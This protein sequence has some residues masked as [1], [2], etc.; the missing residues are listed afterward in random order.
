MVPGH[1]RCSNT[2]SGRLQLQPHEQGTLAT[3]TGPHRA[4]TSALG[5]GAGEGRGDWNGPVQDLLKQSSVFLALLLICLSNQVPGPSGPS[6]DRAWIADP[7]ASADEV[8]PFC[9]DCGFC[10]KLR[11]K[12]P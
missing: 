12:S 3:H 1:K 5:R 8:E 11:G 9:W 4:R 2:S 10:L 6:L 7:R